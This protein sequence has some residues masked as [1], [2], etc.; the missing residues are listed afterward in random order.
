M[1]KNVNYQC[2]RLKMANEQ[3]EDT[4]VSTSILK[5]V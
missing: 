4:G 1:K 2:Q 3:R 5:H